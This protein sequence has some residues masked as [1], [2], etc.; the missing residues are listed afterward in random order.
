MLG[1]I[2]YKVRLYWDNGKENGNY[3]N[4]VISFY[5]LLLLIDEL[6]R[7]M[8]RVDFLAAEGRRNTFVCLLFGNCRMC[9]IMLNS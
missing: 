8:L 7:Y 6:K 5:P 3:Y 2:Y 4:G 1:G 9:A